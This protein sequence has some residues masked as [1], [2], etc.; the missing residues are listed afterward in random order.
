MSCSKMF[1]IAELIY[2]VIK[3][4]Q[5]DYSTLHSCV[6]VNRLWSRLA[7][8]LLWEN[9]FSILSTKDYNDVIGINVIG[10][11]LDNLNGDLITEL[12]AFIDDNL[13]PSNTLFNYPIFLKY[14]NICEFI[15]SVE[16][17][18][19]EVYKTSNHVN[20]FGPLAD[21]FITF[22]KFKKLIYNSLFKLIVNSE[23]KLHILEIVTHSNT[24]V[25]NI[26]DIILENTNFIH[27]IRYLELYILDRRNDSLIENCIQMIN[28]HQNLKKILLCDDSIFQPLSLS[29]DY[30]C[31]NTL[32]TIIFYH[33]NFID[34]INLDKVCEQLNVLESVHIIYCTSLNTVFTQ[35]IIN[36]TKPFKLRSL[37]ISNSEILELESLQLL[38]QNF[39]DHLGNL[40]YNL[41]IN[42][43]LLS[44]QQLFKL[45]IKYCKNIRFLSFNSI[46]DNH[47][48]LPMFKLI[49]IIKQ[50]LNY[51]LIRANNINISS[52]ILQYLGQILPY[53]LE[54]LDLK[55]YDIKTSDLEV[56]LKNSQDTFIKKLLINNCMMQKGIRDD[57][58]ILPYIKEYIMKKKRVQHLAIRIDAKRNCKRD[59]SSLKDEVKEFKLHN[60]KVQKYDDLFINTIKFIKEIA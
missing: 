45:I 23:I 25:N 43:N 59:L 55:L 48:I 56:F 7:I 47:L 31:S 53:K 52:I 1:L 12:H 37:F 54:Y 46:S 4:Y 17:W 6:L 42:R 29:K 35:Q 13:L 21:L 60:I 16:R 18:T 28:T 44:K 8:P 15:S 26:V 11:Y 30:N 32:N 5:N 24:Y 33:V 58:E 50:N 39:G 34:M 49:E 27:N 9:P 2:D 57:F 38:L 51:L 36:L 41:S 40:E 22:S 10:I 14:L 20:S 19:N 3:Y